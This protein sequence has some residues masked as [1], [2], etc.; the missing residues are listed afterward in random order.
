VRLKA[1]GRDLV[2]ITSGVPVQIRGV[3]YGPYPLNQN[4]F[5]EPDVDTI[6]RDFR[7][8]QSWGMNVV[9]LYEVPSR[10][11]TI[12]AE[13]Y[14][15][16]LWVGLNWN[17]FNL[18]QLE[19]NDQ[20][21]LLHQIKEQA[22]AIAEFPQVAV[23]F[24]GNELDRGMLRLIGVERAYLFLEEAVRVVRAILPEVLIT[25]ATFPSTEYL[26]PRNI[27]FVSFNVYLDRLEQW[28][29]YLKHLEILVADKPLVISE[30]GVHIDKANDEDIQ[31][32]IFITVWKKIMELGTNGLIWFRFEDCWYKNEKLVEDWYFGLMRNFEQPRKICK[33]LPL[34]EWVQDESEPREGFS[35]IIC[36]YNGVSMLQ[37]V[38]ESIV[39]AIDEQD[40][41]WVID[42]GS[43]LDIKVIVD[44]FPNI[45]YYRQKHQGLS[46]AR[47]QGVKL[48]KHER[49]VFTDDDCLVSEFWLKYLDLAFKQNKSLRLAGVGGVNITLAAQ[50]KT[51]E[52]IGFAPGHPQV[53]MLNDTYAEHLAGCNMAFYKTALLEIGGF[54]NQY[55][56][57]GDDVD[58]CWRLL[59]AG[60]ALEFAPHA[61][62]WHRRRSTL[63]SFFKQQWF[64]GKA[65]ALLYV[66]HQ[67]HFN[68]EKEVVWQGRLAESS[69][70]FAPEHGIEYSEWGVGQ[71]QGVYVTGEP[72][73]VNLL[74]L[75]CCVFLIC[76]FSQLWSSALLVFFA[77]YWLGARLFLESKLAGRWQPEQCS[78]A[79][80]V[81]LHLMQPLCRKMGRLVGL[82]QNQVWC[83]FKFSLKQNESRFFSLPQK[84]IKIDQKVDVRKWYE[85]LN[86]LFVTKGWRFEVNDD[87]QSY[88]YKIH[89]GWLTQTKITS[90][91]HYL[92]NHQGMLVKTELNW[93]WLEIFIGM[94][95]YSFGIG[96]L[97]FWLPHVEL[98]PFHLAFLIVCSISIYMQIRNFKVIHHLVHHSMSLFKL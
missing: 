44:F 97:W 41:C 18:Y 75:G 90:C 23:V 40:E 16:M 29:N 63:Y 35:I 70:G 88:D 74:V 42:D 7:L 5:H 3:C 4:G 62:V 28:E 25:Y 71:F 72:L 78:F 93:K 79:S 45:K 80:I 65:E 13:K 96:V 33:E 10:D 2:S 46:A 54:D 94:F 20:Q 30:T 84:I 1:I 76:L 77:G 68:T 36:T 56:I 9:R 55:Q 89:T 27:D 81:F 38:L 12:Q 26:I 52:A 43:C 66:K 34:K 57:A 69:T 6:A 83:G 91:I 59:D 11:L 17:E 31:K 85:A 82:Y 92:P 32:E 15:L 48:A 14:Q 8:L 53:V 49:V 51:E 24:I 21:K 47:N 61:W 50:N 95:I 39:K 19:Y 67:G 58:L 60:Y 64:Y 73:N 87:W 86:V 98:L 22:K 37:Q